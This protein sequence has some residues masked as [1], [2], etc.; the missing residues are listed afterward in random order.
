MN[1]AAFIN[2]E[3]LRKMNAWVGTIAGSP[4]VLPEEAVAVLRNSLMKIGLTFDAIDESSYPAAEGESKNV[5]L[6]LTLFG[7]R[8][9]KD[10]DT[11]I[12]EFVNDD[13]IS[14]NVEGGLSLDLEFH[15]QGDGTTFVGAKIV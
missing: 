15:R 3:V 11:P 1:P 2:P 9:G 6:P 8:F 12:D 4:F 10:V 7:G 5:S 14:H 13:G